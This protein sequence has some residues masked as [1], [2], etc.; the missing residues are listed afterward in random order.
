VVKAAEVI[1]E[2]LEEGRQLLRKRFGQI[3]RC[4]FNEELQELSPDVQQHENL[5]SKLLI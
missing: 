3:I 4:E 1:E 2:L 5:A